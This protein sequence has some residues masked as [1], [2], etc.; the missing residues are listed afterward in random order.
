MIFPSNTELVFNEIK[1]YHQSIPPTQRISG[2]TLLDRKQNKRINK[3]ILLSRILC[4]I[5]TSKAPQPDLIQ[6]TFPLILI[7]QNLISPYNIIK[8]LQMIQILHIIKIN[9]WLIILEFII[10]YIIIFIIIFFLFSHKSCTLCTR[11]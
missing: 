3:S 6:I 5:L 11:T 9:L 4:L 2:T 1:F 7:T 8:T 10:N